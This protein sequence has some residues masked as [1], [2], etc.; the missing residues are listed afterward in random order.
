ME[1]QQQIQTVFE[2]TGI[3]IPRPL[4]PDAN[5]TLFS[6]SDTTATKIARNLFLRINPNIKI[7]TSD[8]PAGQL[9]SETDCTLT[10][11]LNLPEATVL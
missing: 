10:L 5:L 2:V 6:D 9:F 4:N 11:T 7:N 3:Q 1:K 8:T